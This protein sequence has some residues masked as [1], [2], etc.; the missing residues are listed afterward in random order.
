MIY[1]TSPVFGEKE[2]GC[3]KRCLVANKRYCNFFI[4]TH[5]YCQYGK[6]NSNYGQFIEG[7]LITSEIYLRSDIGKS[8]TQPFEN[9]GP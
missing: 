2:G 3:A 4:H 1:D 8:N 5:P 6:L 7:D 9:I